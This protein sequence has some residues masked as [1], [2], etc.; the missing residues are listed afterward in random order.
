MY[1]HSYVKFYSMIIAALA[2]GFF[3]ME[4]GV[5]GSSSP[6]GHVTLS[7]AQGGVLQR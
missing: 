3:A 2:I 4:M 5:G 6:T 1:A 7:D